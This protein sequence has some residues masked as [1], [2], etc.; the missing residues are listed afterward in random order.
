MKTYFKIQLFAGATNLCDTLVLLA[1]KRNGGARNI[2]LNDLKTVADGQ[3]LQYP[4][5][6]KDTTAELIGDNLLHIDTKVSSEYKTVCII[7]E[8]EVFDLKTEDDIPSNMFTGA[9][10]E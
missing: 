6:N 5:L 3:I 2:S 1:A 10:A 8:V 4:V 7:E 9:M